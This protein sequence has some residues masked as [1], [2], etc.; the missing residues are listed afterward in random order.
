[1]LMSYWHSCFVLKTHFRN[2][3]RRTAILTDAFRGLPHRPIQ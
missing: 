2:L 3:S 1:L